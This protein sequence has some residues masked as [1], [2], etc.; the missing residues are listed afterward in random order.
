MKK[1]SAA[2]FL[3]AIL[4]ILVLWMLYPLAL[5]F[6]I[7][8]GLLDEATWKN[9]GVF[10]DSFG[11][12]NTLFA[13]MALAGLAF[14]IYLQSKQLQGLDQKEERTAEQLRTQTR[15]AAFT[16]L[17]QTY[18]AEAD[19][20]ERIAQNISG[21]EPINDFARITAVQN[22]AGVLAKRNSVVLQIENILDTSTAPIV[23]D[24]P[25]KG[26]A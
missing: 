17:L 14:N 21:N 16:A 24:K 19:T 15:L 2:S 22:R 23:A 1:Y 25:E 18:H 10:G 8:C 13:G 6:A 12:L 9:A 5:L 3:V 4:L 26:A 7:K 11:A 20:Y